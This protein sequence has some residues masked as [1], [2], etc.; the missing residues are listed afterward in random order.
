MTRTP[1]ARIAGARPARVAVEMEA[2]TLF[3]IAARHGLPAACLLVV[4]DIVATRER[5]G[6]DELLA[7]EAAM[8]RR[9]ARRAGGRS[10]RPRDFFLAFGWLVAR[11]RAVP[12][13]AGAAWA[14]RRSPRTR[15]RSR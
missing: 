10:S 3:A 9:R 13:R 11:R 7:A 2:A 15:A 8:G 4:S 5:I 14:S 12:A 6:A 1:G